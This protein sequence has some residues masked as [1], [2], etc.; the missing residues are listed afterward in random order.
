MTLKEQYR[1]Q[2]VEREAQRARLVDQLYHRPGRLV[3]KPEVFVF[4]LDGTLANV[5]DRDPLDASV[6]SADRTNP[7]V[8]AIAKALQQAGYGIVCASGR[9][10]RY[11]APTHQ[12]LIHACNLTEYLSL[13]MRHDGDTRPDALVKAELYRDE[14]APRFEVL[15]VFDDR[16]TVVAV[17]RWLG[18]PCFQVDNRVD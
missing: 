14:I 9:G 18:L 10:E 1:R 7:A 5:Q 6:C 13:V 2:Q 11:R 12:F 3:S 16:N 4:D 15:G 17:W 8:V